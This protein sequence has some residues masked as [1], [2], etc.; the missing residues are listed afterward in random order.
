MFYL[1]LPCLKQLEFSPLSL[2]KQL[3]AKYEVELEA[4]WTESVVPPMAKEI[5][6]AKW[7]GS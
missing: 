3:E 5:L 2:K 1:L 7:I 4:D 6:A